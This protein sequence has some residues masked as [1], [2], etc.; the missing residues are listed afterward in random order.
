M[1]FFPTDRQYVRLSFDRQYAICANDTDL[2][3]PWHL[4][5]GVWIHIDGRGCDT[6]REAAEIC[7][8]DINKKQEQAA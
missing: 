2:Y 1:K 5:S 7:E 4:D 8:R 6:A 3:T